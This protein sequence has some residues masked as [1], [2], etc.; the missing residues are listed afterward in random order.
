VF[1]TDWQ[2]SPRQYGI[3]IE[4]NIDIEVAPGIALKADIYRPDV[5]GRFP[6]LLALS[7]YS[8]EAQGAAMM[9]V[10]FTYPRAWIEAGDYNFYV[11][12]GY[13]MVI[14]T[15][16]GARGSGGVFGNI[17]P[18]PSTT[19]DAYHAIEWLA[20]QPWC[21]G[22]VGMLGAS[23]FSMIA[24]RVAALKP[25]SLKAIFSPY[26]FSDG[27]RDFHYHGGILAAEFLEFWHRRQAPFFRIEN[28]LR[29]TW[30]EER[31]NAA[32]KAALADSDLATNP[33]LIAALR[34]PD[35]G[36]NAMI[37]E[38]LLQPLDSEFYRA[39]AVDFAQGPEVPAYVGA[40]WGTH[41]HISG[42]I[43]AYEE[44]RGP[45]RL[46]IGPP[47][48]LDRPCYQYAYESLRW[49]DHWMK[50]INTGVMAEPPVHLFIEG[51]GEWKTSSSWPVPGTRW[52][53]FYLH[54]NELLSEHE[55]WPNEGCSTYE[56]SPWGRGEARFWT[57]RMVEATELCGPIVLNLY[58][59]TTD[60]DVLW[61]VS[62]LHEDARGNERLLTRGWLRGSQR[63]IDPARSKPWRPYHTHDRRELLTPNDVYEFNIEVNP[64]G[65]LLKPGERLGLRIKGADNEEPANTVEHTGMGHI[66]RGN[67]SYV[68]VHHNAERPS[69]LLLP[70]T[71]GNIIGTYISGG[72][73]PPLVKPNP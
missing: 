49:F 26:G 41:I 29:K 12:R 66:A 65:V 45:K 16:R 25:P 40:D 67:P 44:W 34:N 55:F 7:P 60:T 9:P 57:P 63:R 32:L 10:G 33:L 58:G 46:T 3:T 47:I 38:I 42:D 5:T 69:H 36:G 30:G 48:Y 15:V 72:K 64:V 1:S 43:R 39:R 21:D 22:K 50:D 56:D 27:Y 52:T 51:T 8:K 71:R 61:F 54:S 2:T 73:L 18:N 4:R 53:P 70:I 31:Y 17:E 23:Y 6:A 20:Q 59:S 11:R 62:L 37:N 14:A 13:A 19:Q 28:S 35:A 68:T 24:K